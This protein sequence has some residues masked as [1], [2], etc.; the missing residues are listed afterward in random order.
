ML[1][2]AAKLPGG[3][4]RELFEGFFPMDARGRTLGSNP[5]P[6]VVL[7]LDGDPE[8]GEAIFWSQ[9]SQCSTCHR[10]GERGTPIGPELSAIGTLRTPEDL[11]ESLL[12]PSRRI[13]PKYASYTVAT[14]D[15]RLFNGLLVKRDEGEV[16]LRHAQNKE[17]VLKAESVVEFQPSRTSLMPDGQI[18]SLTPQEAADLLAYLSSLK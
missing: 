2:E 6:R 11:L 3:P 14:E 17:I 7:T 18:A 8:R 9:Q 16:V 1:S 10:V 5:R 12:I 13:E 15:G 4:I